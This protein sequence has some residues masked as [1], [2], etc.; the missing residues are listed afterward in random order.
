MG[1]E[2]LFTQVPT[3]QCDELER[4]HSSQLQHSWADIGAGLFAEIPQGKSAC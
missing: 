3:A 1:D 4:G 2:I